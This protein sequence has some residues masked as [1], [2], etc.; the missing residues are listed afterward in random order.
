MGCRYNA[1]ARIQKPTKHDAPVVSTG[2][3]FMSVFY[4]ILRFTVPLASGP[5]AE[6]AGD[7]GPSAI[8]WGAVDCTSAEFSPSCMVLLSKAKYY[9]SAVDQTRNVYAMYGIVLS[10]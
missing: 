6:T 1:L 8:G 10:L 4:H 5:P 3:M 7:C 2:I 9:Y